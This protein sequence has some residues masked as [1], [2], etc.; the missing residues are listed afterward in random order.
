MNKKLWILVLVAVVAIGG[1]FVFKN[2]GNEAIAPDNTENVEEQVSADEPANEAATD[3]NEDTSAGDEI[4]VEGTVV[5]YTDGGFEPNSVGVAPGEAVTFV[6]NSSRS[7]WPASAV[8]PTH[9]A[10]PGSDIAKCNTDEADSLFDA[11]GSI[12]PGSSYTFTFDE[13][14]TWNYH[15]HLR[16]NM[17]GTVVVQ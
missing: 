10:Y 1:W 16:A 6:N 11:C 8:H 4:P 2:S 17:T 13:V 15:N 3:T 9:K 14:G 5:V 7:F 12:P